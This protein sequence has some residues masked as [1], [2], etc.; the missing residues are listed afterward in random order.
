MSL[1]LRITLIINLLL[2]LIFLVSTT[3]TIQEAKKNV[4]AEILSS[5]KL[6]LY[7]FEIGVLKN[8]KYQTIE[9]EFKPFNL[10]NLIHMRHI[11]I[12]FFNAKG[13]L[14]DSNTSEI[15]SINQAPEWFVTLMSSISRPWEPKHLPV[16][17]LGD[18]KGD[19]VISPDPSYEYGEIWN[20]VK[21]TLQLIGIFFIL[22]NALVIWILSNA[23]NPIQHILY[24]LNQL[25][26][27]NL[28][29]R[30][31]HLKTKELRGIGQKF[32]RMVKTLEETIA[33]NHHL[34]QQLIHLQEMERKKLA[35]D[36]HDE[37]GQSLTAIHADAAAL[38]VLANKEYPKIKP[39]ADAISD[40][41][42]YL[43]ELVSGMLGLLKLGVLS[44]LGL[45]EGL[46]NL[47]RTWQLRHPKI[48]LQYDVQLKALPTLSETISIGTYRI[49]QECLTNI[50]RHAKA[51]HVDIYVEYQ[52]KNKSNRL[53]YIN[54][55]DDGIGFSKSH[56]D[57]FGLLGIK[58]RIH[59]MNG[60]INIVSKPKCG[61]TLT[62]QLPIQK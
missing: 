29:T 24:A 4:R 53:I 41:S 28:K 43:M 20:Q 47:M 61:T 39:S 59:E 19:I 13:K 8:P 3:L 56:R 33:K 17:I 40:L 44:E 62:M 50:S 21:D 15:K 38:K 37:F 34:S 36:L 18:H 2:F 6:A 54:I 12:E 46:I 27:G 48:K 55:H 23:L 5:E 1:K 16:V 7:L 22:I 51:K 14:L 26:E 58:E 32:N 10:Q 25:E 49:I 31:P 45:E 30:I 9:N 57:G 52:S 35:R 42:K 60:K 11:K